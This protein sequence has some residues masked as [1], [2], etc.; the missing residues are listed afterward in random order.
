MGRELP[1]Y[2]F[3]G[4]GDVG[5][6]LLFDRAAIG[7]VVFAQSRNLGWV[8]DDEYEMS[9]VKDFF[10]KVGGAVVGVGKAV[11]KGAVNAAAS[12]VGL[13]PLFGGPTAQIVTSSNQPGAA[14][15]PRPVN[16]TPYLIGGGALALLALVLIARK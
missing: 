8:G 10:K 14:P 4:L 16:Y 2:A 6:D 5:D 9:G 12:R 13:G 3:Q 1:S 15:P 7:S 11:G